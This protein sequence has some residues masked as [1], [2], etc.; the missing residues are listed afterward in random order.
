VSSPSAQ[1]LEQSLDYLIE[2]DK[3]KR[4]ETLTGARRQDGAGFPARPGGVST[5]WSFQVSERQRRIAGKPARSSGLRL[6]TGH[7]ALLVVH[8]E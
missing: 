5:A 2:V 6:K 7:A 3:L 4:E 1:A 8:L